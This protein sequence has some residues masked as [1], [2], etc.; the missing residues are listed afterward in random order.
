MYAA[1]YTPPLIPGA[2]VEKLFVMDAWVVTTALLSGT[3]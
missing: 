3:A 2:D 1:A